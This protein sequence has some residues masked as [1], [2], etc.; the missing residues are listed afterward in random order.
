MK[1]SEPSGDD[2]YEFEVLEAR[3]EAITGSVDADAWEDL[4]ADLCEAWYREDAAEV[5]ARKAIELG[6]RRASFYL[7]GGPGPDRPARGGDR[8]VRGGHC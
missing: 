3:I 8:R 2:I 7:G 4:A 1:V 6:Q 5:C